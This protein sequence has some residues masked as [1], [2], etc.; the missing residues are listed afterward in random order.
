MLKSIVIR[1]YLFIRLWFGLKPFLKAR[2][3]RQ[4]L[5]DPR[6][7][8]GYWLPIQ[9][10]FIM[11]IRWLKS[12]HDLFNR[13][14]YKIHAKIIRRLQSQIGESSVAEAE[15][16]P[17][18]SADIDPK[19]FFKNYVKRPHPVVIR[20]FAKNLPAVIKW[21][22]TYFEENFGDTKVQADTIK[23][24]T[25]ESDIEFNEA[26]C[27]LKEAINTPNAYLNASR[28]V[29]NQNP[30]L[31]LDLA[32]IQKWKKYLGSCEYLMSQAFL[33]QNAEGAPFHCANAWNFFIMIDGEKEWTFIDP[34]YSIQLGAIVHPTVI[35]VEAC[36]TGKGDTWRDTNQLYTN[37]CPRFTTI[38]RKGDVLLN[39]PWWWHEIKNITPFSIGVSSRWLVNRY[40][41]TNNLFDL[42]FCLS[43][44]VWEIQQQV[45]RLAKKPAMQKKSEDDLLRRYVH[46]NLPGYKKYYSDFLQRSKQKVF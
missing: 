35:S 36:V 46:R 38:V 40:V 16:L 10:K 6:M 12:D 17:E 11:L 1:S 33:G 23:Y 2:F 4:G 13:A 26:Y 18:V 41:E 34:E 43:K 22:K 28:D 24:K 5:S 31:E 15:P 30:S 27:T 21:N 20:N 9:Y 37:Y 42:L 25:K 19:T 44:P 45:S 3:S 14:E 39:P 32:D 8:I 7:N 29:F